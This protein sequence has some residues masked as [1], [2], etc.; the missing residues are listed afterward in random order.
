MTGHDCPQC[1]RY[2]AELD[3]LRETLRQA[4]DAAH[5]GW[6]PPLAWGLTRAESVLAALLVARPVMTHEA[7]LLALY[8]DRADEAVSPKLMSVFAFKLRKKLARFGVPLRTVWGTG[9][10][11]D[12]AVRDALKAGAERLGDPLDWA[13]KCVPGADWTPEEDALLARWCAGDE[14]ALAA[15]KAHPTTPRSRVSCVNRAHRLGLERVTKRRRPRPVA[16][17]QWKRP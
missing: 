5:T 16:P 2:A 8:S 11:F 1:R 7:A 4:K 13:P 10:A 17:P 3:E 15:L 6:A 14:T 12:P 9:Y